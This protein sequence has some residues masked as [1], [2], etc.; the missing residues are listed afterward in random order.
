MNSL[1][2]NYIGIRLKLARKMAGLSLQELSN[3]L[4]NIVTKQALNK[5]EQGLMNPTSEVILELSKS[6]N[7]KPDYF[8]K[9]GAIE[10]NNISFRK[11]ASLSKKSEES[12]IEKAR[13]YIERFLELEA[14]LGIK[15]NFSNP[16]KSVIV[17]NET[18]TS[19]AASMLRKTWE[20]GNNPIP[21]L[22]EMLELKGVKV[23]LINDI[24]DIDGFSF[25]AADSIPVVIV[26]IKSK[27][28][29]RIRFTLIHELAHLLLRFDETILPDDKSIERLCHHF[30][31]CFLIPSEKLIEMIGNSYRNYI[32]I[33]ELISIKEY[34]GISIR[35]IVH[36]LQN[37]GVISSSYYQR[38][39]IYMSKTFGQ[40]NEPGNYNGDEKQ[41]FFEQLIN[42]ALAEDLISISKAAS[43][44]NTS[45]NEIRKGIVSV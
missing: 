26:N 34:Y 43:L 45:I 24:D 40:R 42:R 17:K 10:L 38:W 35:A 31:S 11:K 9:K 3:S 30:S 5:Y 22:V 14:I 32:N 4:N 12:V 8:L 25:I 21:N 29:E 6:L 16:L 13:D 44:M 37:L 15:P 41:R 36:R 39:V 19:N 18:D 27:P 20:L 23:L 28:V 1:N 2:Q 7:V 33:K